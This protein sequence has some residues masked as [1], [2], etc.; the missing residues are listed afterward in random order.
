MNNAFP[1]KKWMC[2]K[3][4]Y[5][6]DHS[7]NAFGDTPPVEDD[8]SVCMN[9]G[10]PYVRH[11]DAWHVMTPSEWASLDIPTRLAMAR[12]QLACKLA[13]TEDLTK[14]YPRV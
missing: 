14:K 11:G 4:G 10:S 12:V 6:M 3:C 9:C 2:L 7:S 13:I 1:D 8:L 5:A